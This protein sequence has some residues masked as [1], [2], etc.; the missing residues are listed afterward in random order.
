[1][2]DVHAPGNVLVAGVLSYGATAALTHVTITDATNGVVAVAATLTAS[3]LDNPQNCAGTG[4]YIDGG[5][6]VASADGGSC[7][8]GS[9]S[10]PAHVF[11]PDDLGGLQ[12]NGGPTPIRATGHLGAP[13]S[14]SGRLGRSVWCRHHSP[15]LPE[16]SYST[17]E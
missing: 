9:T 15:G 4:T 17:S 2:T 6:N 3:L 12:N 1:V 14:P 5:G 11:G 10:D 16:V 13:T 8:F 7:P